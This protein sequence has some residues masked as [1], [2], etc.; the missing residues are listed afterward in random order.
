MAFEARDGDQRDKIRG[1]L[2][3]ASRATKA[4]LARLIKLAMY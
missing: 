3:R 1:A 4:F 2:R